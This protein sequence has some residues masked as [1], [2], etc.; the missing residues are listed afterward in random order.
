M[1]TGKSVITA[2]L[3]SSDDAETLDEL[4]DRLLD[5]M[6]WQWA[7]EQDAEGFVDESTRQMALDYLR[8]RQRRATGRVLT[9][10]L[11]LPAACVL[12]GRVWMP[13]WPD[14]AA[15]LPAH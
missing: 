5:A 12:T 9:Y 2:V 14:P 11:D 10:A 1:R 4:I 15:A 13:D 7:T 3:E 8:C 6:M